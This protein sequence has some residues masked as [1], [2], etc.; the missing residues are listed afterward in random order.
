MNNITPAGEGVN[1]SR[2]K[3]TYLCNNKKIKMNGWS[4]MTRDKSGKRIIVTETSIIYMNN[5]G[6]YW[7]LYD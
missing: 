7:Q 4:Y 2:Y 3:A 1:H 6:E 5:N